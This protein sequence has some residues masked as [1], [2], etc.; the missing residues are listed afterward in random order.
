ML[1]KIGGMERR[2]GQKVDI[3]RSMYSG[4][5]NLEGRI[6]PGM[7]TTL[8]PNENYSIGAQDQAQANAPARPAGV[9]GNAQY[10]PSQNK[11]YWK[12]NNEWKSN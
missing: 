11:W 9:P 8:S 4:L 10:S 1:D 3:M 6:Q 7:Q 5:P 12:E 2:V